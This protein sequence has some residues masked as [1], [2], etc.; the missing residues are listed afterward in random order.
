[1][2]NVVVIPSIIGIG[3]DGVVH[4]H[5]RYRREGPGSMLLVVRYT[6][7]AILLAS[8]TTAVGFGSSLVSSHQGLKSM[9]TLALLGI[10]ATYLSSVLLYPALM[11]LLEKPTPR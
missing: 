5:H 7:A 3:I 10:L 2:F 4:M 11:V 9:G 1:M 6:G 8:L